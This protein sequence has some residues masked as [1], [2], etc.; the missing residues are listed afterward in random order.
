MN[1]FNQY[2]KDHIDVIEKF[3][4]YDTV[5]RV[6]QAI[7]ECLKKRLPVLIFGNGGSA[8]DAMH[9]SAELVGKFLKDREALNVIC[10]NSNQSAL[11]AW[12][13]DYEFDTVF[14][15]QIEAHGQEGGVAIGISTSGKSANVLKGLKKAKSMKVNTVML[16]GKN[17]ISSDLVDYCINVPSLITPLIQECHL[18]IYHYIA[19]KVEENF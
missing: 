6:I 11:T 12:S 9:F 15:R 4:D 7:T 8:A 5:D 16:T 19:M 13:N 1:Q 10:L 17:L 2:K 18:M 14:E 3:S